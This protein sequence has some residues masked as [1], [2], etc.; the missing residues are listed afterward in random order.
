MEE[1]PNGEHENFSFQWTTSPTLDRR[2]DAQTDAILLKENLASYTEIFANNGKDFE[3][4]AERI[5]KDKA[6]IASLQAK[7]NSEQVEPPEE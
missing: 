5:E 2:Q 7:Y 1:P 6:H 4:E 3:T